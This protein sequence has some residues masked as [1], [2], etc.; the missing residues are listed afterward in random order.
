MD[1]RL[2]YGMAGMLAALLIGGFVME[3]LTAPR[4]T[5]GDLHAVLPTARERARSWAARA[6]LVGVEGR[7]LVDG[8][9]GDRGAWEFVF[10][11]ADRPSRRAR[12]VLG[13]HVL[14][15]REL[16]PGSDPPVGRGLDDDQFGRTPALARRLVAHGMRSHAPATFSL[17]VSGGTMPIFRVQ[18]SGRLGGTWW[19]DARSGDLLEFRPG[20]G[21]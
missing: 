2:I 20:A 4:G 15:I 7:D 5:V 16:P 9:N 13:S 18:T 6:V 11:D 21:K 3:R 17:E 8:R 1:E 14:T 19:I 10:A 12:V